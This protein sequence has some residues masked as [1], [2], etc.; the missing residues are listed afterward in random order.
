MEEQYLALIA[1]FDEATSKE[2]ERFQQILHENGLDG[3]Q[4]PDVPHHITM[5]LYDLGLEDEVKALAKAVSAK[6]R[7]FDLSFSHIGLFGLKVL[8]LGP[9]VN[10]EL[11]ELHEKLAINH[12]RSER[13]WT[14]HVTLLIDETENIHTALDLVVQNF[15]QINARIEGLQLYALDPVRLIAEYPLK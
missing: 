11:L 6:T 5:T 15:Q 1:T 7:S 2:M 13:G 3:T 4:T 9:D 12:V 14:P 8:F 10:H